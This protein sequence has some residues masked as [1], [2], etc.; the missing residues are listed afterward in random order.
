ML[1][2]P[3]TSLLS[4]PC[5]LSGGLL[6]SAGNAALA[7]VP[8]LPRG[9]GPELTV[10]TPSFRRIGAVGTLLPFLGAADVAAFRDSCLWL[11]S[12]RFHESIRAMRNTVLVSVERDAMIVFHSEPLPFV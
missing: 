2:L 12:E 9:T 11:D 10:T 4:A 7:S 1:E 3:R 5:G 6:V 8:S